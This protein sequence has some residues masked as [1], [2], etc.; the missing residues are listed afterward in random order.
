MSITRQLLLAAGLFFVLMVSA[1]SWFS[2]KSALAIQCSACGAA[3]MAG[4]ECGGS[5]VRARERTEEA[6]ATNPELYN[7]S[8]DQNAEKPAELRFSALASRGAHLSTF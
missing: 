2:K 5:Y 4:S 1:A 8:D 3:V 7:L 6:F